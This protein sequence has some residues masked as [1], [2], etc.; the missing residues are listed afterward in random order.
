MS[1]STA[2]AAAGAAGA[3]AA[4]GAPPT[5]G[6]SREQSAVLDSRRRIDAAKPRVTR[7]DM[8]K[9]AQ[10][11]LRII[12]H[13][14]AV[15]CTNYGELAA[16]V[17][18][19]LERTHGVDDWNVVVA[20]SAYMNG[21]ARKGFSASVAVPCLVADLPDDGYSA[22]PSD[23]FSVLVY[24][25][26]DDAAIV[27]GAHE[28]GAGASGA[29]A[30]AATAGSA[31]ASAS[32][33]VGGQ[34]QRVAEIDGEGGSGDAGDGVDAGAGDVSATDAASV[35]GGAQLAT[36]GSASG[37]ALEQPVGLAHVAVSS[38]PK[39]MQRFV[40]RAVGGAQRAHGLHADSEGAVLA[41]VRAAVTAEFGSTWHAAL[42]NVP[43]VPAPP[44]AGRRAGAP[45]PS[46]DATKAARHAPGFA[47]TGAPSHHLELSVQSYM[48]PAAGVGAATEGA[49]A[50]AAAAARR[51]KLALRTPARYHLLLYR[52]LP[53][54]AVAAGGAGEPQTLAAYYLADR[55]KLARSLVYA[56]AAACFISYLLLSFA[57]DNTC[58][59]NPL[60]GPAPLALPQAVM[61]SA[62]ADVS[63]GAA[64]APG[65]AFAAQ[66]WGW[67]VGQAFLFNPVGTAVDVIGAAL[68]RIVPSLDTAEAA[69]RAALGAGSSPAFG[70]AGAVSLPA[71][72]TP[73]LS[74]DS[75][76]RLG[77][78]RSVL[79]ISLALVVIGSVLRQA[80]RAM[81][82][83]RLKSVLQS[84]TAT[85]S[86]SAS[87]AR[88]QQ[89]QQRG[90][91]KGGGGKSKTH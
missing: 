49:D 78:G 41:D 23:A 67:A 60:Q 45:P 65:P 58:A 83:S 84:M 76:W 13:R 36:V 75:N 35:G 27:R 18:L 4:D 38:M 16:F 47:V 86:A 43:R 22:A 85:A 21:R 30:G 29:G 26:A 74:L 39:H 62:G 54:T 7:S 89:Q 31:A 40:I 1:K 70:R 77:R 12:V 19:A 53:A 91:G 15:L 6:L 57:Y 48:P 28:L 44:A 55:W 63:E 79:Y 73:E 42:C 64:A 50:T 71:Y 8:K 52:T 56:T 20:T 37:P 24:R 59:T 68:A 88:Q 32:N 61:P 34:R 46:A 33:G 81:A 51:E 69:A 9:P 2:S 5:L 3:D 80:Q 14:A 90:S 10:E 11:E 17:Q 25:C 87:A 82:S 66:G 72:C